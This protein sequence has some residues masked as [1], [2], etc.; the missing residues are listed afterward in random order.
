MLLVLIYSSHH[1]ASRLLPHR[2]DAY[3]STRDQ[4]DQGRTSAL[5]ARNSYAVPNEDPPLT[6]NQAI[7][8]RAVMGG[9]AERRVGIRGG[10][11][12]FRSCGT[13]ILPALARQ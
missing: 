1:L 7:G 11:Q 5:A 13:E 4:G 6:A 9:L 12:R 2:R 3:A 8:L 10:R